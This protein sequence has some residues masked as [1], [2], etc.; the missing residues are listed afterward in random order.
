MSA[1]M[2]FF[3]TSSRRRHTSCLSDWSSDV[4]SSDLDFIKNEAGPTNVQITLG[5]VGVHASSYPINLIYLWN[6]GSE[7]GVVQV[8]LKRGAKV[9]IEQLK[10]RLRKKFASE[11]PDVSFSFEPS[12]IV[13]R[14]MSLAPS[15]PL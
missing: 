1:P 7:E 4:C 12:D 5:F 13:S 3:F 10:E 15:P 8:Q 14:V 2:L 11:L 6:G 9:P